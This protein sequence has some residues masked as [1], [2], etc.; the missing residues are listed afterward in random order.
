M[1]HARLPGA[2]L[3]IPVARPE[4]LWRDWS[5]QRAGRGRGP[6]VIRD[7]VARVSFQVPVYAVILVLRGASGRGPIF[8]ILLDTAIMRVSVRRYGAFRNGVR[9]LFGLPLVG[10][11]PVR[12]QN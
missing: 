5:M 9:R 8:G 10:K 1:L 7:S 12:L 2:A 11:Q 3:T 6:R 4:C